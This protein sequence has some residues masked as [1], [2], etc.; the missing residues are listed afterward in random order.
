MASRLNSATS[1]KLELAESIY[2]ASIVSF[3]NGVPI[4]NLNGDVI[5]VGATTQDLGV[6]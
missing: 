3:K 2:K 5:R 6:A 4:Y 1:P